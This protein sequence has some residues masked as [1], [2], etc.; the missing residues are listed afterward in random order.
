MA[1]P[2][3]VRGSVGSC[4][5]TLFTLA[6]SSSANSSRLPFSQLFTRSTVPAKAIPVSA[7]KPNGPSNTGNSILPAKP[8]SE[9]ASKATAPPIA[10]NIP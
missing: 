3:G 8:S 5:N 2:S 4:S 10:A 6:S 7:A 9:G 1:A